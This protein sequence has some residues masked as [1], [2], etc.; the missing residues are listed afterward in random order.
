MLEIEL[1]AAMDHDR[2][3]GFAPIEPSERP[4]QLTARAGDQ[5]ARGKKPCYVATFSTYFQ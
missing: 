3:A 4:G 5:N 1:G 2:Q